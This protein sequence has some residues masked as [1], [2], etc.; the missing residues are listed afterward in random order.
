MDRLR[1]PSRGRPRSVSADAERR[2]RGFLRGFGIDDE[3]PLRELTRRLGRMAPTASAKAIDAAAGHWFAG[4]LGLPESGAEMA[5]AVGRIAW[6]ASH[7]GKR[8]PLALFADAPP[9]AL[10]ET[11]RRSLPA[12]PPTNLADTMAA[13]DLAW[14]RPR[15]AVAKPLRARTA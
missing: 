6:L 3:H 2:L 12:L 5:L 11:L 7:A 9:A 13:A 1:N 14:A 8:W 10:A 4:L 15:H